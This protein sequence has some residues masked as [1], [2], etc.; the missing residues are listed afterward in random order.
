MARLRRGGERLLYEVPLS[1]QKEEAHMET[2][3]R[4][5]SYRLE[6]QM[7]GFSQKELEIVREAARSSYTQAQRLITELKRNH[8]KTPK[9]AP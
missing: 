6:K 8:G 4:Y 2:H 3:F 7:L 5:T 9:G 1:Q